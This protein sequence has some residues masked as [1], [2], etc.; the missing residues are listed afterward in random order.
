MLYLYCALKDLK[1]KCGDSKTTFADSEFDKRVI[2]RVAQLL[3]NK[4]LNNDSCTISK[5][6]FAVL[7]RESRR[8]PA[9]VSSILTS[10]Y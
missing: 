6:C 9:V 8:S 4:L 5:I 7:T 10:V 3:A 1:V 2:T